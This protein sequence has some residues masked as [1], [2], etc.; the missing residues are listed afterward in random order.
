MHSNNISSNLSDALS[1][2]L[3]KYP[4]ETRK[5]APLIHCITN[6]VTACDVANVLLAAGASPVMTDH[7]AETASAA[8]AADGLVLNLGTLKPG[9]VIAMIRAGKKAMKKG[10]PIVF[11]PV[12][13]GMSAYRRHAAWQILQR[14]RVSIIRGNSSEI[15]TLAN[16][17]G[18]PVS[19]EQH[20]VDAVS[21][22]SPSDSAA[23]DSTLYEKAATASAA[24]SSASSKRL[25]NDTRIASFLSKKLKAVIICTGPCDLVICGHLAACIKNGCPELSRITGSG[26]MMD[27][28]LAA[29]ATS[30]KKS[31]CLADYEGV[32]VP[33]SDYPMSKKIQKNTAFLYFYSSV[34]AVAEIGLCGEKAAKKMYD[35][36][37]GLGSFHTYFID[38]VSRMTSSELLG[39]QKIEIKTK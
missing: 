14:I 8:S 15:R 38:A 39:G 23:S 19:S 25:Y 30:A 20:G 27:G 6:Y 9:S 28:L 17:F 24:S 16:L 31:H 36:N 29:F 3:S 1:N 5:A 13:I 33:F 7:P 34:C 35:E 26:C 2:A 32:S 37:S 18:Y 21:E 22:L 10:L 4:E 12:G 11:D